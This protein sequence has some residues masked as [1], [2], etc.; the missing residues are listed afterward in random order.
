MNAVVDAVVAAFVAFGLNPVAVPVTPPR[1]A[2]ADD[3]VAPD[4]PARRR[5]GAQPSGNN[6]NVRARLNFD[7]NA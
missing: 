1:A 7:P 2:N 6:P 5:D 3:R 4:A